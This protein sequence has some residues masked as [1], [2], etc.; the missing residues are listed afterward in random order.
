[1]GCR[2]CIHWVPSL[3]KFNERGE[4]IRGQCRKDPT[5]VD[6]LAVHYCSQFQIKLPWGDRYTPIEQFNRSRH[7]AWAARDFQQ[8][9]AIKAEKAAMK[10][11]AQIREL[12][13]KTKP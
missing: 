2:F 8:K 12:K 11:R 5:A 4:P 6:T 10:L 13:A 9:R 7:E 3:D 1:M